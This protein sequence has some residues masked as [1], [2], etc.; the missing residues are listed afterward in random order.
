MKKE[1]Q[2]PR[3]KVVEIEPDAPVLDVTGSVEQPGE[4]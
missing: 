1:Y 2:F 3:I 4:D